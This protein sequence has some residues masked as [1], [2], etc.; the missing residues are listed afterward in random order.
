MSSSPPIRI[1]HRSAPLGASPVPSIGV[2]P[3]KPGIVITLQSITDIRP[4]KQV[5]RKRGRGQV[6]RLAANIERFGCLVPILVTASGE[7]I[8]GHAIYEAC[9]RLNHA[10]VPTIVIDH[11]ADA[12]IKALHLSL[13]RI[14]DKSSWD[15]DAL[16][17]AFADILAIEPDLIAFTGFDL[18]EVDLALTALSLGD[19]D[20]IDAVP[21]PPAVPVSRLGDL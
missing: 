21:E 15:T 16:A 14:A 13:N 20:P 4:S 10:S 7:I 9:R 8:D 5:L 11:L 6:D 18:P 1:R 2:S 12:E 19:T 3:P 17:A